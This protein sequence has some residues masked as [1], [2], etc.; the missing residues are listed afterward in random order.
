MLVVNYQTWA[1]MGISQNSVL[2]KVIETICSWFRRWS[3]WDHRPTRM[4]WMI[5]DVH[6]FTCLFS[7]RNIFKQV[8]IILTPTLRTCFRPNKR[9]NSWSLG[10]RRSIFIPQ[11]WRLKKHVK[12]SKLTGATGP[13]WSLNPSLAHHFVPKL[14][15]TSWWFQPIWK[16]LVK[17]DRFPR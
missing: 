1:V 16:I 11:C 2:S 17:L 9:T 3:K 4:E 8:W 10:F 7:G 14:I 6:M 13:N 12:N 5:L 15:I